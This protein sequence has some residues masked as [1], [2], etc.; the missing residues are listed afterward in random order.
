MTF[1]ELNYFVNQPPNICFTSVNFDYLDY[2]QIISLLLKEFRSDSALH[3]Q[4]R[5]DWGGGGGAAATQNVNAG[6]A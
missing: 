2:F 4:W 1:A 3:P 5:G 6:A